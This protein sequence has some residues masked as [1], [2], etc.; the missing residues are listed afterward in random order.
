MSFSDSMYA[1]PWRV[2]GFSPKSEQVHLGLICIRLLLLMVGPTLR[3][4]EL[5]AQV[6]R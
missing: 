6:S 4:S 3:T 2:V 5:S 1:G